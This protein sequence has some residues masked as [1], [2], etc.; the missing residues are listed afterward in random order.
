MIPFHTEHVEPHLLGGLA[1]AVGGHQRVQAGVGT[2]ALL[3]QQCAAVIRHDLVDV[4]VVLNLHLVIRLVGRSF[5]PGE[6]GERTAVDL[7]HYAD[8]G[9]LFDLHELLQLDRWSACKWRL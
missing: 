3:D 8:V 7:G 2:F 6:R 9:A 4:F 1:E 5:V